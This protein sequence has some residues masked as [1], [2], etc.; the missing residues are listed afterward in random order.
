MIS[1]AAAGP[2]LLEG[3]SSPTL[4]DSTTAV[5]APPAQVASHTRH[6]AVRAAEPVIFALAGQRVVIPIMPDATDPAAPTAAW[7]P[8][9]SPRATF[10]TGEAIEGET[11]WISGAPRALA[12]SWEWLPP[13][14]QWR[15]YTL[16][17]VRVQLEAGSDPLASPGFWAVVLDL[18]ARGSG[19]EV[20][21][22]GR[23]LP[24]RWLP[25]P[26]ATT[27][28]GRAPQPRGTP[29]ALRALGERLREESLD[30][31]RRWRVRLMLDRWNSGT[32]WGNDPPPRE[33]ASPALEALAR[34]NEWRWR[35]ALAALARA[36]P[37][38]A[39]DVLARV[40]AVAL[41]PNGSLLPAWPLDDAAA[42]RL[43]ATLLRADSSDDDR[44]NEAQAWLASLPPLVAWV[45]DDGPIVRSGAGETKTSTAR[46]VRTAVTELTGKRASVSVTPEGATPS[47]ARTVEEHESL[48]F[49]TE[50]LTT[51]R[52]IEPLRV[53]TSR[54]S[55][56]IGFR[57]TPMLATPP[58]LTIGPLIPQW[59]MA[60]W[61]GGNA[62]QCEPEWST[63]GLLRRSASSEQWEVYIECRVAPDAERLAERV[64]IFWGSAMTPDH[65]LELKAPAAGDG[66]PA[67]R[68]TAVAVLPA[69]AID[70]DGMLRLSVERVDGRGARSTWPRP[71]MPDDPEPSRAVIDL[72][73]WR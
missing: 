53:E 67:D 17:E 70:A 1:L 71:V 31:L 22:D 36:G 13:T 73:A 24:I 29:E 4:P 34:Q 57:A 63:A 40:T 51:N 6:E 58:G 16:D 8:A 61:L 25:D 69:R 28:K 45:V 44:L 32:L 52:P 12:R 54:W 10:V 68:W 5:D 35:A 23:P 65:S 18:P 21:L 56:R 7:L 38:T 39:S 46:R 64:R 59:R 33:L 55:T 42:A 66:A 62:G 15:S 37:D 60:G 2:L 27:D 50:A 14:A 20:R 41:M 19:R 3:C 48:L 11:V 72:S 47:D 30:P 49:S 9:R 26:P 43:R